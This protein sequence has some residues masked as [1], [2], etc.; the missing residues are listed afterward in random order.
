MKIVFKIGDRA[1]AATLDNNPTARDFANLLPM[2]LVLEDYAATEKISYLPRKLTRE[3]APAGID[4]SVGDITYYAPWGNLAIFHKD[5]DY[6]SGLI[7]L[8]KIHSGLELLSTPGSVR[9]TIERVE[10]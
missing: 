8:G 1:T 9:V 2:S 3:G 5:F 10:E 4:P 7:K 6:S